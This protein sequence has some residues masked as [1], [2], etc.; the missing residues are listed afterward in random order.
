MADNR[1]VRKLS[2]M[3]R[4][5]PSTRREVLRLYSKILNRQMFSIFV[6]IPVVS[7]L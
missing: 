7:F 1:G 6:D 5:L 3:R 2:A 4:Y